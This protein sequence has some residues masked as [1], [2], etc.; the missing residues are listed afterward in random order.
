MDN[1]VD[2]VDNVG[3]VFAFLAAH[4]VVSSVL[5]ALLFAALGFVVARVACRVHKNRDA[6][7]E[8]WEYGIL[9]LG[10]ALNKP[11]QRSDLLPL[12]WLLIMWATFGHHETR[13]RLEG[14]Q[15]DLDRVETD[16]RYGLNDVRELRAQ[17]KCME[18]P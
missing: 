18:A 10:A 17:N 12:I 15:H 4:P 11:L 14:L 13:E 8:A 6:I 9:A 3:A 7:S 2:G 1:P 5:N 16:L